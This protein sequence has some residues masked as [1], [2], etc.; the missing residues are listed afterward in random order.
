MAS[1]SRF[2]LPLTVF[3]CG[4]VVMAYEL[5]G[6]RVL[7]PTVGSS[8]FV[9]T[10]LIGII[11]ASL[12]VGYWYGGR[13]ADRWPSADRLAYVICAASVGILLTAVCHGPL[14]R[15]LASFSLD[16]RIAATIAGL[17]LFAPASIALGMVSPYA[18]RLSMRDVTS[19]GATVGALYAASTV[20]S[21]AGTF[22]TGWVLIGYLG[23]TTVLFVLSAVAVATSF[24]AHSRVVLP[25]RLIL[26]CLILV[27]ASGARMYARELG[28]QGFVDIDTQYQ[29]AQILEGTLAS[30]GRRVR[31]FRTDPVGAQSSVYLDSPELVARYTQAFQLLTQSRPDVRH[32]LTIGGGAFVW[33]MQFIA[34]APDA[35]MDVVE[36]DPALTDIA[37]RYFRYRPD[38]RVRVVHEDGRTFLNRVHGG[39]YDLIFTDAFA[40]TSIPVQLTTREALVRMDEALAD[41]GVLVS[42]LIG[43]VDG[44]RGALVRSMLATYRS[45]FEHVTVIPLLG[46]SEGGKLQNI[47][48]VSSHERVSVPP[49]LESLVRDVP[50]DERDVVLTDEFAPVERLSA[51]LLR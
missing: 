27:L 26:L 13:F 37:S 33:P 4:A 24:I 47:I 44:P 14:L 16:Q 21:I 1:L 45:V 25:A 38:E 30:D 36:I 11:L 10:S 18:A 49:A 5:V 35:T 6:S 34:D 12:S 20:G 9:W 17:V 29:R 48:L 42:N 2:R 32:A 23:T 22:L 51:A 19:S 46:P 8:L 7:A 15:A 43:A 31:Y 41:D 50:T 40:G 28:L 39:A 3:I